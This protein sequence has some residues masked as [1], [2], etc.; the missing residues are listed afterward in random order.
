MGNTMKQSLYSHK[1]DMA[2]ARNSSMRSYFKLRKCAVFAIRHV[3][4]SAHT[5]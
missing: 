4:V 1:T 2:L 3:R 5:Q